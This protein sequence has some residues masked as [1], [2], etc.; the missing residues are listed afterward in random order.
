M[1]KYKEIEKLQKLRESGGLTEE[2]FNTEKEKIL[3]SEKN[4]KESK[5]LAYCVLIIIIVS[6]ILVAVYFFVLKD[7]KDDGNKTKNDNKQVFASTSTN[8]QKNGVKQ[9]S[10]NNMSADDK[11]LSDIQREI[12]NY[13]DN[14]YFYFDT[15][16]AQRYPQVFTEAKVTDYVRVAKVLKSSNEEFEMVVYS[17]EEMGSE[18]DEKNLPDIPENILYVVRGEQ[19]EERF[20]KDD[21]ITV[22]G[23]YIDVESFEIDGKTY[24]L[25]VVK[26]I[27]SVKKDWAYKKHLK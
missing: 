14:N 26:Y 21:Y 23:R 7:K 2:E 24:S 18:Y 20:L 10:F 27:D 17:T 22:Y 13:F 19:Q 6:I 25:P 1:D 4:S 9:L 16:A 5:K 8:A 12:I 15:E 3:N 11:N